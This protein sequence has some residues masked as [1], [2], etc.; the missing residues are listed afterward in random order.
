[1][2]KNVVWATLFIIIAALLESTLISRLAIFNTVPDIALCILVY[3]SYVN[4]TMMGE[5]T[6]FAGG[7]MLDFLSAAPLG[8]NTFLR[9]LIGA[10]AGLIRGTFFLDAIFLPVLLCAGATALKAFLLF[11]LHFLFAG[12]IISYSFMSPVLWL[13]V[14]L[15]ALIAPIVFGFLRLFNKA[16]VTKKEN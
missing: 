4:G 10:S 8:L 9:T 6:G 12:A 5:L 3:V 2:T 15:N 16:L 13:E 7:L 11:A 1:M 14:G